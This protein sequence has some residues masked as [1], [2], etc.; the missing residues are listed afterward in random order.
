MNTI[1]KTYTLKEVNQMKEE[2]IKLE[3]QVD[4]VDSED[5]ITTSEPFVTGGDP[6]WVCYMETH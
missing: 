6:C 5:V 3:I 1:R 2:Y 4:K